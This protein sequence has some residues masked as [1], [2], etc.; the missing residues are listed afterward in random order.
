[1]S[2][3]LLA[4]TR[5]EASWIQDPS[6]QKGNRG[7]GAIWAIWGSEKGLTGKREK[8][9]IVDNVGGHCSTADF[10]HREKGSECW[11]AQVNMEKGRLRLRHRK[12][13]GGET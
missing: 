13:S 3:D 7:I 12:A 6:G 11:E 10:L 1:M 8:G 4:Q 9:G 5:K 2:W